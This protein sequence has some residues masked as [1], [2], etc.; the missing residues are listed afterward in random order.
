MDIIFATESQPKQYVKGVDGYPILTSDISEAVVF[1][2]RDKEDRTKDTYL[3][4]AAK[5]LREKL[6]VQYLDPA[7]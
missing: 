1:S 5:I 3:N 6:V 7:N 2:V 4:L